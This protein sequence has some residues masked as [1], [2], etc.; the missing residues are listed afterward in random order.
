M[1]EALLARAEE[2][3]VALQQ[4]AEERDRL[5]DLLGRAVRIGG[6]RDVD[7]LEH[8]L[9]HGGVVGDDAADVLEHAADGILELG[10]LGV[11]QAP[12]ELEVHDRLVGVALARGA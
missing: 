5:G 12:R 11:A 9:A 7:H 3:E 8:A 2:D 4:P 6:A 10:Q 1:P